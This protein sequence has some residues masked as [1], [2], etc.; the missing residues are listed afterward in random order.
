L[1]KGGFPKAHAALKYA[2]TPKVVARWV[3][4]FEAKR[5]AGMADRSSRPRTS[6]KQTAAAVAEAIV[7]L[8]RQRLTGAH[9]A[10]KTRVSA[11]TVSRVLKRAGLK[12]IE[13]AEPVRR[14]E[15]EHHRRPHRPV[16]RPRHRLG[17]R[18]C[19]HR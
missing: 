2:V 16:Q 11:A 19:R 17:V 14:Y 1:L 12:D 4:R 10:K 7:A 9:I 3:A 15:R 13:P 6:P 18:P 5:S 8:R